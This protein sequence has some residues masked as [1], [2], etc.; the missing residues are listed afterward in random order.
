MN[1]GNYLIRSR[2]LINWIKDNAVNKSLTN[3][4]GFI[5]GDAITDL[6]NKV[7]ETEPFDY[8]PKLKNK[9]DNKTVV[10]QAL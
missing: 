9:G 4:D 5:K 2:D 1:G 7:K 6:A 3:P 10:T 8:N